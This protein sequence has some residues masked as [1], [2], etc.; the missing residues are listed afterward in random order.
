MQSISVVDT[1]LG[2]YRLRG[3]LQSKFDYGNADDMVRYSLEV[4]GTANPKLKRAKARRMTPCH[5]Q[6]RC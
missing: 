3:R 1:S 4:D 5:K 6:E 2:V